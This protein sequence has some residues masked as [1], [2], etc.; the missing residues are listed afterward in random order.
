MELFN[1]IIITGFMQILRELF[2]EGN[3]EKNTPA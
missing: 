3:R 2:L 1:D